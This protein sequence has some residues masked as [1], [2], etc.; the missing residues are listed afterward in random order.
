M[1]HWSVVK[2]IMFIVS[3]QMVLMMLVFLLH[4]LQ[5]FSLGKGL[6]LPATWLVRLQQ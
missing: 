4:D 6:L 3:R 5:S 2:P 1:L